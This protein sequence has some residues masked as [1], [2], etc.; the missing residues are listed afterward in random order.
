MKSSVSSPR[1]GALLSLLGVVLI[2][3]GFF[4]P[5]FYESNPQVPGSIHPVYEWQA[6]NIF[7]IPTFILLFALLAALP[8]V[9]MLI[10]LVVNSA[11][12]FRVPLSRSVLLKRV[13]AGFGLLLQL[14]FDALLFTLS[15]IGYARVDIAWGLVVVLVGFI[16]MC[17]DAFFVETLQSQKQVNNA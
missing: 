2:I 10:V 6:I 4:L 14:L 9:G 13:G 5:M 15:G 3:L 17:V 7:L 16:L 1:F 11:E 8:F 12:L